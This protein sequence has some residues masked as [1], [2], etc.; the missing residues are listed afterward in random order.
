MADLASGAIVKAYLL[1]QSEQRARQL[2]L[3]NELGR[4]LSGTLDIQELQRRVVSG[5]RRLLGCRAAR[6]WLADPHAEGGWRLVS[7]QGPLEE[8]DLPERPSDW[9]L[10]AVA[11]K[12][13]LCW[14]AQEEGGEVASPPVSPGHTALVV[15]LLSQEEALGLLE[16]MDKEDGSR[17]TTDDSQLL[18]AF[19][20]QAAVAFENARLYAQTDQAL[21]ARVEELSALELI[22][23]ELN[24]SLDLDQAMRI[25]LEWAVRRTRTPRGVIGLL[26]EEGNA[27]QVLATVGLDAEQQ[28]ALEE[29]GLP[30]STPA[31]RRAV[32][33]LRVQHLHGASDE[34]AFVLSLK[35]QTQAVVPI[36]REGKA[37]GLLVLER[38]TPEGYAPEELEFLTR[39]VEHAAIAIANAQ[40]YEAIQEANKAKSD[41]V[42]FVAHELKTP[43][44]SIRGYAD[45]LFSGVVGELNENQRNFLGIIRSNVERMA[46]LVSDL[47]DI[48]RIEAGRL[49][50]NFQRVSVVETVRGV[51]QSLEKQIEEKG[52]TL[53]LEVPEDLPEV[54]A[55]PMRL[56]Q[57]LTNLLSNAYK[58]T[59]PGGRITLRAELSRNRWDPEGPPQV[60]HIT[61]EDTGL[62][63]HPDEQPRIFQRFFRSEADRDAREQPG[64]GLGLY[65]TKTLVE[66]QGGQIWFESVYREGTTFHFTVPV[67]TAAQKPGE[68]EAASAG[69]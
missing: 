54:W 56:T 14:P 18:L 36:P 11:R 10:Q 43:M 19:A 22:D 13:P 30:L 63:I 57:V 25:T 40:L 6:L 24:A 38:E 41:F 8:E 29:N 49:R 27:L 52:Q 1:R 64:T 15:P 3:L 9:A 31:L 62:G 33:T 47:A 34:Q 45:L 20:G 58:Y 55:D 65:I 42:S 53:V 17:F 26:Q 46:A 28:K 32:Q 16:V 21:A 44:T 50:L 48:S 12:G 37:I 68:Q 39:L 51:V 4:L 66:M 69:E 7:V 2:A 35:S 59:P 23:R 60:V 5:A 61:V 67:A